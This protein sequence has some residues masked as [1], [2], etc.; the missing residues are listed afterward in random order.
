MLSTHTVQQVDQGF[1]LLAATAHAEQVASL[2]AKVNDLCGKSSLKTD[3]SW[4]LQLQQWKERLSS[5]QVTQ[6]AHH[7]SRSG[8]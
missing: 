2:V 6:A 4:V 5:S 7:D 3:D 8:Q 1:A